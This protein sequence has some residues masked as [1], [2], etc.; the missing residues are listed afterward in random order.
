M[1]LKLMH[2]HDDNRRQSAIAQIRESNI[3]WQNTQG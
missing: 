2:L 1:F 3:S